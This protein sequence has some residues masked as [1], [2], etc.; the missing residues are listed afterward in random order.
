MRK[1]FLLSLCAFLISFCKHSSAQNGL[2]PEELKNMRLLQ[3]RVY[4]HTD[5]PYYYPGEIIWFKA[6]L[7]YAYPAV[8]D[9]LSRLLYVE[10]IDEN[11]KVI[12]TRYLKITGGFA[13]GD[14]PISTHTRTGNFAI[15]AYTNWMRNYGANYIFQK[16]LPVLSFSQAALANP[17]E[18]KISSP[19][20]VSIESAKTQYGKRELA[21]LKLKVQTK[22]GTVIPS[23]VSV[24]VTDAEVV[25]PPV[26]EKHIMSG[27]LAPDP[28][29]EVNE[30]NHR[31][32]KGILIEAQVENIWGRAAKAGLNVIKGKMENVVSMETDEKG[33][34]A[35]V[36]LDFSDSVYFSFQPL[37]KK[38]KAFGKVSLKHR[39]GPRVSDIYPVRLELHEGNMQ[40]RILN[41]YANS[42]EVKVLDEVVVKGT[43]VEEKRV[44]IPYGNPDYVVSGK[45]LPAGSSGMDILYALQG[46]VPGMRVTPTRITLRG[47]GSLSYSEPLIL[48]DGVLF[49][50]NAALNGLSAATIEKI[51]IVKHVVTLYGSRGSNGV[52]SIFTK[53]ASGF[54]D[55]AERDF[56][57]YKV[58]GY[59]LPSKFQ[60]TDYKTETRP[61]GTDARTT[62]H[63]T[64]HLELNTAEGATISF[65]T[66]DMSG[67]YRISVEGI[68]DRGVPVKGEYFITVE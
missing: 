64:P 10:L 8:K 13:W 54:V 20:T 68:T 47:N 37:N 17:V 49:E 23:S 63:W 61:E 29:I 48:I 25:I 11:K 12:E 59:D 16:T 3:E 43:K 30:I 38:D 5:K 7:T 19:Y 26:N 65:Y 27:F 53:R 58:K 57:L 40:S 2:S 4:L 52:I 6:Y 66:A 44:G 28:L 46:R 18:N 31:L 32:E 50:N 33:Y 34:F 14:I 39:D 1:I 67:R 22:N 9:S 56:S 36:D 21:E 45:Q 24:S 55:P 35:L 41:S 42:D 51:E 15:R 62:I 60:T